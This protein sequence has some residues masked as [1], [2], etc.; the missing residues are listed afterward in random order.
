MNADIYDFFT[1]GKKYE[2]KLFFISHSS[3]KII[4]LSKKNIYLCKKSS[5]IF[6]QIWIDKFYL[7]I[8]NFKILKKL[9]FKE[10][11]M[12]NGGEL[13]QSEIDA[14]LGAAGCTAAV[15]FPGW[16]SVIGGLS[17]LNWLMSL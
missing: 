9:D 8:L 4:Y 17:C 15:V 16:G 12:V 11:E 10:M 2:L 6:S 13:T 14:F 7:L 3:T 5:L 1:V